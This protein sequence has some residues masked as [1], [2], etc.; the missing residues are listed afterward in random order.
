ME[1]HKFPRTP[2]FPW[3][4]GFSGDDD[5]LVKVDQFES[6]HE[7]IVT[8]KLDGE[9]T[10]VYSDGYLH[11][12]SMDG[13]S[14]PSRDWVKRHMASRYHDIPKDWRVCGESVYGIHSIEYDN[15]HTA[16]FVFSVIDET[17]RVL[18]WDDIVEFCQLLDL[19]TVPLIYRG[20]WDE[21]KIKN[22]LPEKSK[23]GP[24]IEGYVVR[25]AAA[26]DM[27]DYALNVAKFVRKGHIQT[28]DH[29]LKNWKSATI[30][31]ENDDNAS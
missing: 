15:L 25:N 9:N 14:H 3:S 26:F 18:S 4:P 1:R 31:K 13:T 28:D 17:D 20:H 6:M 21:E 2:H 11:A 19:E 10:S 5:K 23:F 7:I 22:I 8:E 16:F 27:S 29:W 24:K 30:K 12:R